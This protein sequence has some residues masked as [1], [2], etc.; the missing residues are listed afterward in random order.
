MADD[1]ESRLGGKSEFLPDDFRELMREGDLEKLK[2]VYDNC[3][4]QAHVLDKN[5]R[6]KNALYIYT[7]CSEFYQW[8]VDQGLDINAEEQ[9]DT[10][11]LTEQAGCCENNVEG[12][13][14]AGA[15]PNGTKWKNPM[16]IACRA[17][18]KDI[19]EVLIRYGADVNVPN[20]KFCGIT[21]LDVLLKTTQYERMPEIYAIA[22]MLLAN[23]ATSKGNPQK[24]VE[25]IG[26]GFEFRKSSMDTDKL[27]E[28]ELAMEKLYKLF[29][30]EP[31][32]K[33]VKHDGISQIKVTEKDNK[34]AFEELWESLV[35][36]KGKCETV[37]GEMIRIAGKLGH[38]LEEYSGDKR[39]WKTNCAK[40]LEALPKYYAMGKPLPPKKASEFEILVSEINYDSDPEDE[41]P[42]RELVVDWVRKNPDPIKLGEVSYKA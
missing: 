20:K 36:S 19:V 40:M 16:F 3:A 12:L 7:P 37:Q 29:S 25:Q 4:I 27:A 22:E 15:D 14:R 26:Q 28:C 32:K 24:L 10:T 39:R 1:Y 30:V 41:E 34:K 33:I 23:K 21:P 9:K 6:W 5:W 8:L 13:L 18:L 42:L 2:S 11:P 17:L 35:P 31:V 38:W